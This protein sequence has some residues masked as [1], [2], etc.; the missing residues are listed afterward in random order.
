MVRS[1]V[2]GLNYISLVIN[3]IEK[4]LR[5]FWKSVSSGSNN[6]NFFLQKNGGLW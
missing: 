2:L 4:W 3:T 5:A 6:M 1:L